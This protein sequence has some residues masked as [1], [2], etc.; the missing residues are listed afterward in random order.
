MPT[1]SAISFKANRLVVG[2]A[3]VV[4]VFVT[5]MVMAVLATK[6]SMSRP[7]A[8]AATSSI[9][10][11]DNNASTRPFPEAL[12]ASHLA[13]DRYFANASSI[14]AAGRQSREVIDMYR[15]AIAGMIGAES[16]ELIFTS[17]A[18]ESNNLVIRSLVKHELERRRTESSGNEGR[19]RDRG[20]EREMDMERDRERKTEGRQ[21]DRRPGDRSSRIRIVTTPIEHASIIQTLDSLSADVD[22]DIVPVDR[23]GRIDTDAFWTLVRRPGVAMACIILAN[24]EIGTIQDVAA[25]SAACKKAR[26]HLHC[27]MTQMFGK[28]EV[29]MSE[30]GVD[31]ATMSSHKFHGPKGIGALYL[32]KG[33]AMSNACMTGGGQE[34]AHR[35]G[36]ENIGG[37]C[38]MAVALGMCMTLLKKG[39]AQRRIFEMREYIRRQLVQRVPGVIVHGPRQNVL[40]NTL[41]VSLPVDSRRLV[42][43]LDADDVY[44]SVGC[45]CSKGKG[46]QTLKAIGLGEK[47]RR[48]SLRIS[49]GFFNVPEDCDRIVHSISR[50]IQTLHST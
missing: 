50:G 9:V 49:L 39:D 34:H 43:L 3:I 19:E 15:H 37:V 8:T 33:V 26:V 10:Y 11:A 20:G 5:V 40:Y 21:D 38:G 45:A 25:L 32:R 31:S 35:G 44:V 13:S 29:N 6:K 1:S 23:T 46:S 16:C 12:T 17:G 24:N 7:P 36:T 2:V 41:S 18:T 4:V 27:D 22:V 28:Y 42:E 30:L 47:E 14:H 48:G